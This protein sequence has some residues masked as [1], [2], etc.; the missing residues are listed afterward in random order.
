M[1]QINTG[2]PT[3]KKSVISNVY[4]ALLFVAFVVLAAA[5]VYILIRTEE[6]FGSYNP[7]A[8]DEQA[9]AAGHAVAALFGLA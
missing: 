2:T 5:V 7:F 9:S 1:S 3:Q 6:L 4:T 8:Q